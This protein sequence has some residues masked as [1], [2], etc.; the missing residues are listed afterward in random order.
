MKVAGAE[1][2]D[3]CGNTQLCAGLEA[4]IE[5]AVQTDYTLC[6]E[7]DNE[8]EWGYFLNLDNRIDCLWAV[9]HRWPS[10]ARFSMSCYRYQALL[11]VHANDG[12]DG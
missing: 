3:A 2:K 7:R 8:D 5:G 9:R 12:Y 10:G 11:L 4:G 1:V 6:T